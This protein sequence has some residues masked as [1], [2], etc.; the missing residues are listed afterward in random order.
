MARKNRLFARFVSSLSARG[1]LTPTSFTEELASGLDSAAVSDLIVNS[2]TGLDSAAVSDLISS[3]SVGLDSAAVSSLIISNSS[4]D[5]AAILNLID[6]DYIS[7]RSGAGG[8]GGGIDAPTSY[9]H[10]IIFGGN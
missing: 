2:N 6:S 4:I 7:A 5:S 1:Q 10:S 8:G 3:V 9:T